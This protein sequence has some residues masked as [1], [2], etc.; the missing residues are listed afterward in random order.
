[1][2][3]YPAGVQLDVE[4]LRTFIAVVDLGGMT[5]AAESLGMSQS[6]VSWKVKRLEAKAGRSL[7]VR[8]GHT[9]TPSREG[10][11]LLTYA[12]QIVDTHDQAVD[13]LSS[14]DLTGS[15]KVGAT[16]E[17]TAARMAAILGRFNRLHP[18]ATI[19]FRV[20]YGSEL[21]TMLAQG[22]LDV[23]VLQVSAE[24]Y[25]QTDTHLW[26]NEL[27]WVTAFDHPYDVGEVPLLTFGTHGYYRPIATR[28]LRN[29]GIPYRI[30]LSAPST[31]AIL[32]A[33]SAGLGVAVVSAM[34]VPP[35]DAESRL[36]EWPRSDDLE[37]LPETF[38]VARASPGEVSGVANELISHINAELGQMV[39][40][41]TP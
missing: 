5:R 13:Q 40:T 38:Q 14:S 11:E 41:S 19:E 26:T 9:I 28:R 29:A 34:S 16:E 3:G 24:E 37:P 23:A 21:Q 12:R 31:A 33:A 15:V 18:S 27:L 2:G 36:I 25:Q 32:A 8:D 20:E 22:E 30:G 1:M 17:V 6:A 4:S 35:N 7:L 10:R 39:P